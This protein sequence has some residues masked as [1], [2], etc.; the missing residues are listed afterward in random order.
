MAMGV[1]RSTDIWAASV[2]SFLFNNQPKSTPRLICL[3]LG[4]GWNILSPHWEICALDCGVIASIREPCDEN[5]IHVGGACTP[6]VRSSG[7]WVLAATIL[8]SSMAFI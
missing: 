1:G 3:L 7:K 8:G 2:T 6:C 4:R 5:V